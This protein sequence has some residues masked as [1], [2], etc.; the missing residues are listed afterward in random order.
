MPVIANKRENAFWAF[1]SEA[2][3]AKTVAQ[4]AITDS[5]KNGPKHCEIKPQAFFNL[6]N[7]EVS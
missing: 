3:K 1:S 6:L 4:I 2:N 7:T 5:A